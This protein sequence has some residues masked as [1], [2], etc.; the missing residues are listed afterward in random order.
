MDTEST[1]ASRRARTARMTP[2]TVVTWSLLVAA[3][4]TNALLQ[5]TFFTLYSVTSN[6]A[7]FVPLVFAALAQ[8][9]VI[10]GGGL[11]LSVG[12]ITALA[13]VTALTVMNGHDG[14]TP[15]GFA[16]ALATGTACGTLNGLVVGVLRLQPLI[17]TFATASVFSGITLL[18]L[19]SP[20]GAVPP[21]MTAVY[22]MAVGP[23][24]VP[25]LLIGVCLS[26]WVVLAAT[27]FMRHV[28]AVGSDA[29]AAYASLVPVT[30][31]RVGTYAVCGAIASLAALAILANTGSGDPF[32]GANIALDSIA[33]CVLGGIALSGG[34]GSGPGAMAGA[35]ILSLTSNILFFVGVPTTF[36][37]LASGL[38]IIAA[39]ALSVLST[40]GGADRGN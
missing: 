1:R 26:V 14:L 35:L 7:T 30:G 27:V 6:L 29:E 20:G 34:R 15:L 5:P 11:D 3:L 9:V 10:I 37:Q 18:V 19:P 23:L 2:A 39:L 32:I 17:A 21:S 25:L 13:S 22:R 38:V 4:V 40:R 12:A 24:P 16:A 31:V 8:A 33:A 36:R 28:K